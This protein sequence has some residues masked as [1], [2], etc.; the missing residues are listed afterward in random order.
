MTSTEKLTSSFKIARERGVPIVAI[1]SVDQ[2]ATVALLAPL[3]DKF[4]LVR[5]DAA[6]GVTALNPKG[7][8][9]MRQATVTAEDGK[10]QRSAPIKSDETFGFA[11][12]MVAARRLPQGAVLFALNAMRQLNTQEP[13]AVAPAVQAVSNLRDQFKMDFRMLVA[14]DT[15]VDLPHAL[16]HDVVVLE[17]G[18][19]TRAELEVIVREVCEAANMD[20]QKRPVKKVHVPEGDEM[21]RAVE[22]VTGL[23]AFEAEQ[24]VSIALREGKGKELGRLDEDAL[25]ERKRLS[26]EQAKMHVWRGPERFGDIVGLDAIKAHAMRRV[27]GKK[28]LGVVV[29]MEETDKSM[30]NVEGDQSGVRSDQMK[31]LLTAMDSYRWRGMM[32]VGVSG[33]GK[34]LFAKALG[35]EAGVPVV[36]LDLGNLESKYVGDSQANIRHAIDVIHAVGNGEAYFVGTSNGASAMRPEFQRRFTDG[37]WMFDLMTDAERS[38]AWAHYIAKYGLADKPASEIA[39]PGDEGWTGA[40]IHNCCAYAWDTTCSLVEAARMI[41]P[42][43]R[44]RAEEIERLRMLADNRFLDVS[45]PGPYKY[46]PAPM[47]AQVKSVRSVSLAGLGPVSPKD[48]N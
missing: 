20:D 10:T 40:E 9:A 38:A 2:H 47:A 11:D 42:M 32:L 28:G 48:L 7:R 33:G 29:W 5:W 46:D 17:H 43:A 16:K 37:T 34:S 35:G 21:R 30:A 39:L 45:R 22:A 36:E 14:L 25:W 18:F 3:W 26:I 24:D 8:D 12:A 15:I 6:Q 27:R 4:P 41:V 1:A 13:L 44:A 23:S 19:P 31:V